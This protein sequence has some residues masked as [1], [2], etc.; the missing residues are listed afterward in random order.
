MVR[1]SID[2]TETMVKF[3][4]KGCSLRDALVIVVCFMAL[5]LSA[6]Y[7]FG[8]FLHLPEHCEHINGEQNKQ[9]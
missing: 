9:N 6:G 8:Q 4:P 5:G 2:A 1:R 3:G 7:V